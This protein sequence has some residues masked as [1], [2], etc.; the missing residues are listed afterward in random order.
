MGIGLVG[1]PP[2][3]LRSLCVSTKVVFYW[4]EELDW[5][6]AEGIPPLTRYWSLDLNIEMVIFA[7]WMHDS[8]MNATSVCLHPRDE[9]L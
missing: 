1:K 2:F 7:Q 4:T 6:I 8:S 5:G 3:I 9:R